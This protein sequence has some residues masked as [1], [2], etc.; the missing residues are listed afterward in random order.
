LDTDVYIGGLCTLWYRYCVRFSWEKVAQ[1]C[2]QRFA[3]WFWRHRLSSRY[4][5]RTSLPIDGIP[6]W[7]H[8]Y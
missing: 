3:A 7:R 6:A 5:T 2:C 4:R 1:S 8:Y